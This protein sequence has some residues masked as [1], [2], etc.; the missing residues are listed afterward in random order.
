MVLTHCEYHI[1]YEQIV[2]A[3]IGFGVCNEIA[4]QVEKA[5]FPF[6]DLLL[7]GFGAPQE[8]LSERAAAGL[9]G[10]QRAAQRGEARP[11]TARRH[12]LR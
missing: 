10:H 6:L 8:E 3:V 12:P 9:P 1:P 5:C 4:V 2:A 7:A 11:R